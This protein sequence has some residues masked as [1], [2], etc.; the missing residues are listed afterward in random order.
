[1]TPRWLTEQPLGTALVT[2][3]GNT[4]IRLPY[5]FLSAHDVRL[6]YNEIVWLLGFSHVL[7]WS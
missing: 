5:L 4:R 3:D 7:N 2:D 6:F 1:M